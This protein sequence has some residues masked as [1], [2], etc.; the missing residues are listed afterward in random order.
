MTEDTIHRVAH[1]LVD[2]DPSEAL[3][4]HEANEY[5]LEAIAEAQAAELTDIINTRHWMRAGTKR[6]EPNQEHACPTSTT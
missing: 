1:R 6:T 4:Q 5:Q 3:L 2:W